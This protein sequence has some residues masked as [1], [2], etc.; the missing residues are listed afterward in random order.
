M[1]NV[2]TLHRINGNS[3]LLYHNLNYLFNLYFNYLLQEKVM[4]DVI[5]SNIML[6]FIIQKKIFHIAVSLH[7]NRSSLDDVNRWKITVLCGGW[8]AYSKEML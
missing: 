4:D 8:K 3:R 1:F 2:L 6:R 5:T 7:S